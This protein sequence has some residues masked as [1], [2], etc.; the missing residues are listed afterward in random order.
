MKKAVDMQVSEKKAL[1]ASLFHDCAKYLAL[2][3]EKLSGFRLDKAYG[4]VP[5][6]VLHQ[7][8]GA[9]LAEEQFGVTDAET[10]D[11]IRYHTSGKEGMSELG[12]IIF[13]A[14]MVEEE[15]AFDGVDKLRLLF[16]EKKGRGA[17]DQCLLE[18]LAQ[19]LEYLRARG[20]EI[21]PLTLQAYNYY[22]K[23]ETKDE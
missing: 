12:K 6:S 21:Y 17:L 7:F 3:D 2:A 1:I 11:A 8:T 14:D 22:K 5:E 23:G 18:A 16:Y 10:L 19:T 13:L 4:E 20:A 9:Y 15:R